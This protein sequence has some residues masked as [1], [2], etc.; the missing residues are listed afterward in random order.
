MKF[1]SEDAGQGGFAGTGRAPEDKVD[2]LAFFSDFGEDFTIA[3][4]VVLADDIG[5]PLGA[6]TFSKRDVIH[7]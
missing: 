3:Q 2:R 4:N 7:I 1:A 5:K 6:H